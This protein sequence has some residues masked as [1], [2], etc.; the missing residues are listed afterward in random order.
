M[1]RSEAPAA[2]DVVHL[3][4]FDPE[5]NRVGYYSGNLLVTHSGASRL[6]PFAFN[7]Q[8]GVW[9]IRVRDLHS[10]VTEVAKPQVE[11]HIR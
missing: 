3:D 4:A 10:G 9:T 7:D 8:P 1:I 11:P 5:G 2:V 6:L